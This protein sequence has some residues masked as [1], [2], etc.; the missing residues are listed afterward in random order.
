MSSLAR[1]PEVGSQFWDGRTS[2]LDDWTDGQEVN[3][4]TPP[5]GVEAEPKLGSGDWYTSAKAQSVEHLAKADQRAL[6]QVHIRLFTVKS[7]KKK[8]DDIVS[9]EKTTHQSAFSIIKCL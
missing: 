2:K 5:F 1:S 8:K 6:P 3:C 7:K 9:C 4:R